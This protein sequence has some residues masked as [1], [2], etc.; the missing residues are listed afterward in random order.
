MYLNMC[1]YNITSSDYKNMT[2][3]LWYIYW[4]VS[5]HLMIM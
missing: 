2:K 4:L 1:N 5:G 3:I